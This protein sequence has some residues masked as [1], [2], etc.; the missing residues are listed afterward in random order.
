MIKAA[1]IRNGGRPRENPLLKT[2]TVTPEE[3]KNAQGEWIKWIPERLNE[4]EKKA[5]DEFNVM[6]DNNII[7]DHLS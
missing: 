4:E 5:F 7:T 6:C 2:Y 1:N 3:C